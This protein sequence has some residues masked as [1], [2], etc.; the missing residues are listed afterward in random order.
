MKKSE[1]NPINYDR[2]RY[3]GLARFALLAALELLNLPCGSR[4]LVPAFICRDL[5]SA[6]HAAHGI[7]AFYAVDEDLSPVESNEN[8]PRAA[9]VIAVNYFGFPQDLREFRSYCEKTGAFLI[10]D[11]AHGFLSADENGVPLGQRGDIGL[12]SMRKTLLLPNGAA[13][14]VN[15]KSLLQF[16]PRQEPLLDDKLPLTFRIKLALSWLQ[17]QSGVSVLMWT[18]GI[19]RLIRYMITGYAITPL[20]PENEF[21]LPEGKSP[22]SYL[23]HA[24]SNTD[25]ALEISRRINLYHHFENELSTYDVRS[26]FKSLP[27]NTVPYGYPFYASKENARRV[28][29][30]ARSAGFDCMR[31]PDLPESVAPSAPDHYHSLWMINFI[32]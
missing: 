16:I 9:V 28:A 4:I 32:C 26:V 23:L 30:L 14:L 12:L 3:Y 8:W 19:V 21:R 6:I 10:E 1:N 17:R 5:L 2:R 25:H 22:H 29:R 15:N 27:L 11:N 13:L 18:Q 31:W 7:P 24:I 20:A